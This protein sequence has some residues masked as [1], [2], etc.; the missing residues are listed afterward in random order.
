[1]LSFVVFQL[2]ISCEAIASH[3][4][5]WEPLTPLRLK[6]SFIFFMVITDNFET[7]EGSV[8]LY[9]HFPQFTAGFPVMNQVR[10]DDSRH[11]YYTCITLGQQCLT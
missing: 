3:T 7:F 2:H 6:C 10:L 5:P 1:M 8:S 4:V 9:L 11:V